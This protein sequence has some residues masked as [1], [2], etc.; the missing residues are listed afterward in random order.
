MCVWVMCCV[1]C[2]FNY[3]FPSTHNLK[4]INATWPAGGAAVD[5]GCLLINSIAART[6]CKQLTQMKQ[7]VLQWGSLH[8]VILPR[9][10]P[11]RPVSLSP[12]CPAV[13]W[14]PSALSLWPAVQPPALVFLPQFETVPAADWGGA[15]PVLPSY[16]P[17]HPEAWDGGRK[18][19]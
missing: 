2:L 11:T 15:A 1:F 17:L 5:G 19:F 14:L 16:L 6:C 18:Q 4:L 8:G 7:K 10:S 13:T 3:F 9:I 12:V